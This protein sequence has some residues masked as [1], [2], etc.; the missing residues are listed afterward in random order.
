M[1]KVKELEKRLTAIE[2]RNK[3]VAADKAWE[4][5]LM[6]RLVLIGLTYLAIG[7]YLTSS[8]STALGLT[9]LSQQLPFIYQL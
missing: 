8:V 1:V 5:S 4:T 2:A 9:L 6:R 7:I 3:A